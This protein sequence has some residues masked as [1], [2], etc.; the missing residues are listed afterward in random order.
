MPFEF[1]LFFFYFLGFTPCYTTVTPLKAAALCH[2]ETRAKNDGAVFDVPRWWSWACWFHIQRRGG[3]PET[4]GGH[5]SCTAK[6][7][8]SGG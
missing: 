2:T 4:S 1:F 8:T 7:N 3:K 6:T 5:Q